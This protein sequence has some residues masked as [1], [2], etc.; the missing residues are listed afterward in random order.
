MFFNKFD[1]YYYSRPIS[2]RSYYPRIAKPEILPINDPQSQ[3]VLSFL[4]QQN[5]EAK[6]LGGLARGI[7]FWDYELGR[8]RY[9]HNNFNVADE[10][11]IH[12]WKETNDLSKEHPTGAHLVFKSWP[13]F[14]TKLRQVIDERKKKY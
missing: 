14:M 13:E 1:S 9:N 6:N 10:Y 12:Q 8:R 3:E 11:F 4:Q 7:R 5:I 2:Y